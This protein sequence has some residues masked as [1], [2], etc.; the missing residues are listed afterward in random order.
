[1]YRKLQ[2]A[3]SQA[4]SN[5]IK[6]VDVPNTENVVVVIR[7][8]ESPHAPHAIQNSTKT[9]IRTRSITQPYELADMDRIQYMFKRRE[10]AQ[11]KSRQILKRIKERTQRLNCAQGV[12]SITLIAKPVFPYRPVISLSKLFELAVSLYPAPR[13]VAG[14][15]CIS[16]N[17]KQYEEFTD[18]QSV[19]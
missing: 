4:Q 2:F 13:R 19:K 8:N 5:R 17:A 9:Y 12:P 3:H 18:N 11:A 6:V 1:M 10:D 7:V 14:G 15:V 16:Q